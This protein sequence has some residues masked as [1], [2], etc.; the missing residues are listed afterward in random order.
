MRWSKAFIPT[1]KEDPS[2]A[3]IVSHKLMV[4]A[5]LMRRLAN[6]IFS[7]LPLGWRVVRKVETIVREEMNRAGAQELLMPIMHPGELW[8][9]T[10]RWGVYGKELFRVTDRHERK[11]ALGPTHE[12]VITDIVRREVRSYRD[13]PINLYQIQTKFRDEVRPRFGVMRAREFMMK[14]AYSFHSSEDSLAET[15]RAMHEA[16]H[17]T[18]VRCGLETLPVRADSGAIGGDVTHEFMVLAD[19]GESEVFYCDCG[20]N[21]T[22]D[23]AEAARPDEAR[24]EADPMREVETP[25]MKTVEEVSAFLKVTPATLVK[26]LLYES[27][28]GLVA[29]LVPGDREINESKLSRALAG[30]GL[31]MASPERIL[32]A[33][34]APVGFSGPVGLAQGIRVIADWGVRGMANFVT[35]AN[36]ADR[37]LIN[38]NLGRDVP[39]FEMADIAQVRAGDPCQECGAPLKSRRGIEV[40][41]IFKLGTKYSEAM[42]ATYLGADGEARPFIMGCYGLGVT[43]TVA[44]AIEAFHDESG[45][46]WPMSIAPYQVLVLPVNV[47][48]QEAVEV[49]G[50]IYDELCRSG[51]DVLLDDREERPGVKFKDADLIGIPLRVTVGEKG[52]SQ[53]VVELKER[54]AADVTKVKVSEA[55][56]AARA[57]V[58]D[59]LRALG[60]LADSIK[61]P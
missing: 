8:E 31:E 10:G 6:G 45:I 9:E 39:R 1:L 56:G 50:S 54:A 18:F 33:T 21:A 25:G 12:E 15:Y 41:Q 40:G 57:V 55:A 49:A 51:I 43:R 26:T 61:T 3:E 27:E 23:R 11:F 47:S 24:G 38:V 60:A 13:L 2:D 58:K 53:G 28:G 32:E 48:N 7:F 44:A 17:R 20:Y 36:A 14:D 30:A 37:H 4:R 35:G 22:G 19:T 5:G 52:L 59:R 16:Y 34:G 42:G 29:A 46:I